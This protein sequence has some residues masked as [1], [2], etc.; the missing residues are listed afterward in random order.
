M[1]VYILCINI[2]IYIEREREG[3]R[4]THAASAFSKPSSRRKVRV[5]NVHVWTV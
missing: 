1:C 2:Y 4:Y 5:E 3:E